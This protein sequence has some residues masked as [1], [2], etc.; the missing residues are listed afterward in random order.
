LNDIVI[1]VPAYFNEAQKQATK[2]AGFLADVRVLRLIHEPTAAC[3]AQRIHENKTETILVADLGAGTFDL[4]IIEAGDGVFEVRQIEGD[5][6]LGSADLDEIIYTHFSEFVKNETGQEIPRN[7]QAATRLRQACEELKIELS[8][9]S[10]WTIDLPYLI[11]DAN[12]Q[13]TLTRVE[14]EQLASPWLER[15]RITCRKIKEKPSRVLLIGGGGLMPAVRRCIRDVFHLEP[16]SAYD[17]LTIVARGA[18]LQAAIL[19]GDFQNTLLLDVVPFS[20]GIKCQVESGEFKFNC[21]I[22]KH[23]TIPTTKTQRYTT[24]E[25]SQTQVRIEVFQG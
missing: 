8:T 3:L 15:I 25:D 12:T 16:D 5:N 11:G 1:T 19:T 21:V 6:A 2:T 22:S 9:Q 23:T 7:S 20:L 4:S 17:P 24:T 13:L 18:S 14:L 10:E